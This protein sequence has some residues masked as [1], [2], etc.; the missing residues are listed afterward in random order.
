[1]NHS[2][3]NMT[4]AM[5]RGRRVE[6]QRLNKLLPAC[7]GAVCRIGSSSKDASRSRSCTRHEITTDHMNVA[8]VNMHHVVARMTKRP[9][10]PDW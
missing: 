8:M 2:L 9:A 10:I 7:V 1:M 5:P 3:K 4:F 6:S